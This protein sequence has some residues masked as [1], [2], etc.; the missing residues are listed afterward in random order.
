MK[1]QA[2]VVGRVAG[3]PDLLDVKV[4][5]DHLGLSAVALERVASEAGLLIACGRRK[6]LRAD[7]VGELVERCRVR[8]KAPASTGDNRMVALP[9]GSSKA[10]A[11]ASSRI[12]LAAA[13]RLRRR[14]P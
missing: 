2:S 7:E 13:E 14:S 3:L 10:S 8:P 1:Q 6:K 9:S 5:A 4:V 12:A 11:G